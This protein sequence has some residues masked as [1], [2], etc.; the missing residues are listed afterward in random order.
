MRASASSLL[1]ML[2]LTACSTSEKREHAS[3]MNE[4]EAKVRLPSGAGPLNRYSRYYTYGPTGNVIGTY[5]GGHL[6]PEETERKWVKD[7]R[8]LPM[9]TDGECG[10]VHL[11]VNTKSR[12][13]E[14][15]CNGVA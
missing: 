1:A 14:V 10:V 12:K 4:V 2:L 13:I 8:N 3:I 7:Y 5:V 9:I 11:E 15:G 6:P